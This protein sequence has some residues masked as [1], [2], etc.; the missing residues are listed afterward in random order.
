M[1]NYS[2]IPPTK[3]FQKRAL[4]IYD[5]LNVLVFCGSIFF[6]FSDCAIEKEKFKFK[7]VQRRSFFFELCVFENRWY[8][9]N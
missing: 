2:C 3:C 8:L 6:W 1:M 7:E 4:I 9:K 5:K